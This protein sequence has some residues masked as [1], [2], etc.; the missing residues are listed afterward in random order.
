MLIM[1]NWQSRDYK[2]DPF[3]QEDVI[4]YYRMCS[5]FCELFCVRTVYH[6]TC[7]LYVWGFLVFVHIVRM[8][9][10]I[11]LRAQNATSVLRLTAVFYA[12]KGVGTRVRGVSSGENSQSEQ[13][14]SPTSPR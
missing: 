7:I 13:G 5:L 4:M 10:F 3:L 2:N 9:S 6:T 1:R 12:R 8:Q 11:P 14:F